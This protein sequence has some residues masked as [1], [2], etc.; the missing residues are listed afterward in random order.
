MVAIILKSSPT[1]ACYTIQRHDFGV[2]EAAKSPP[3]PG[4]GGL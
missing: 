3:L 4:Q 2:S 1:L